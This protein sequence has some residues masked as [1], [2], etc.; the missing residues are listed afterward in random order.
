MS[1]NDDKRKMTQL[2]HEQDDDGSSG[3]SGSIEFRDF[4]GGGGSLRD[5]MLPFDEQKRLLAVHNNTH[6]GR[7]KKQKELRDQ[8]KDLKDGKTPLANYREGLKAGMRS[9][10]PAHPALSD[11]AQFSGAD[12]QVN[13][14]PTENNAETNDADRNEL[15]A[16]YNLRHRPEVAPKFNP[17]P[18]FK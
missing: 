5:D 14:L 6:E 3:Q 11:K 8:R 7:V 10:Y 2:P 9:Q 13:S 4:I 16:Q 1:A 15:Q 17:K 12:R 18:Q